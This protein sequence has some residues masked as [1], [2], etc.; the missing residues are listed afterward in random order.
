LGEKGT[1]ALKRVE[2]GYFDEH[3]SEGPK[4]CFCP[5]ATSHCGGAYPFHSSNFS[6]SF[7]F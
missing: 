4:V 2:S 3:V 1:A 6:P 7:I 5:Y